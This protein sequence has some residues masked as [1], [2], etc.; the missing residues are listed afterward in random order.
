MGGVCGWDGWGESDWMEDIAPSV[1][2]SSGEGESLKDS[3]LL[4]VIDDAVAI[5]VGL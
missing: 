3:R 2:Y 4:V 1:L 5:G